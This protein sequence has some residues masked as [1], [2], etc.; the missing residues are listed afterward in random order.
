MLPAVGGADVYLL[1]GTL[2][3]GAE[4]VFY[5][6]LNSLH[7][8]QGHWRKPLLVVGNSYYSR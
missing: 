1:F 7:R 2:C 4:C 5:V 8:F 6:G 3:F